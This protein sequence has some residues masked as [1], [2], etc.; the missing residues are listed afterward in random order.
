MPSPQNGSGLVGAGSWVVSLVRGE[1]VV[2]SV[3]A[4]V[5]SLVEGGYV[6][7]LPVVAM[8]AVLVG[9]V[10][11]VTASDPALFGGEDSVT[12]T[13]VELTSV[14]EDSPASSIP[15]VSSPHPAPTT[16]MTTKKL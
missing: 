13:E 2:P 6:D 9:I 15:K 7:V 12:T 3:P 5:G 8:P 10:C 14:G 16:H 4:N 11:S 1:F